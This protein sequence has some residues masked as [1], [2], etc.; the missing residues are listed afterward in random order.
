MSVFIDLQHTHTLGHSIPSAEHR[1]L[2]ALSLMC[3]LQLYHCCSASMNAIAAIAVLDHTLV[4][5][6]DSGDPA[7]TVVRVLEILG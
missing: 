7:T 1:S 5:R 3:N 4:V 6:P 2:I